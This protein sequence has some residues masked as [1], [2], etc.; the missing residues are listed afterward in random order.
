M[1]SV[2]IAPARDNARPSGYL[3]QL[4]RSSPHFQRHIDN[5]SNY[6]PTVF[7]QR[8]LADILSIPPSLD[9]YTHP[10]NFAPRAAHCSVYSQQA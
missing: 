2:D 9:L 6:P 7:R 1:I 10:V 8:R 5:D 4:L 3:T